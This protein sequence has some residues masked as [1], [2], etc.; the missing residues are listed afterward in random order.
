MRLKMMRFSALIAGVSIVFVGCQNDNNGWGPCWTDCPKTLEG[1]G[2]L[3]TLTDMTSLQQDTIA[4]RRAD[5]MTRAAA[6]CSAPPHE[7]IQEQRM[8]EHRQIYYESYDW[9]LCNVFGGNNLFDIRMVLF[10]QERYVGSFDTHAESNISTTSISCNNAS[11][12]VA[13]G[14]FDTQHCV[15][16]SEDK[17]YRYESYYTDPTKMGGLVLYTSYVD[18]LE[19][20]QIELQ[21][22]GDYIIEN[23]TTTNC[24]PQYNA[25]YAYGYDEILEYELAFSGEIPSMYVFGDHLFTTQE[26]YREFFKQFTLDIPVDIDFTTH[27]ALLISVPDAPDGNEMVCFNVTKDGDKIKAEY[28]YDIPLTRFEYVDGEYC[29]APSVL[30]NKDLYYIYAITKVDENVSASYYRYRESYRYY[31]NE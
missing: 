15:Y 22:L 26:S 12:T 31:E 16:E 30:D 23:N 13:A 27:S 25:C 11:V 24:P 9:Q 21:A 8:S 3:Y 4:F 17:Q 29:S 19:N 1:T 5:V 18:G 6:S 10:G 20:Y 7:N 14:T 28:I 2:G